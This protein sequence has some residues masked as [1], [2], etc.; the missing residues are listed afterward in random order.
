[1]DDI[2]ERLRKVEGAARP[3]DPLAVGTNWYRNPDGPEAAAEI[4]ALRAENERLRRGYIDL[5][6]ILP[7]AEPDFSQEHIV[8]VSNYIFLKFPEWVRVP[9]GARTQRRF[10]GT[11]QHPSL[12]LPKPPPPPRMPR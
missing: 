8:A 2:A 4:E 11:L 7:H 10:M 12:R 6:D 3:N 1:M 9:T 5:L